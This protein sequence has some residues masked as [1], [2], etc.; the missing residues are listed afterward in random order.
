MTSRCAHARASDEGRSMDLEELVAYAEDDLRR[1][2]VGISEST[3]LGTEPAPSRW[4]EAD[5]GSESA[6]AGS[7][8]LRCQE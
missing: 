1:W 3:D 2:S 8:S 4:R 7:I 6:V 5:R